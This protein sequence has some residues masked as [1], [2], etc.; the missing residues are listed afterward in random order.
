MA[1]QFSLSIIIFF[2]I[3]LGLLFMFNDIIMISFFNGAYNRQ[4]TGLN[5][6]VTRGM[7]ILIFILVIIGLG[8]KFFDSM[9][10][11]SSAPSYF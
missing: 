11:G 2:C 1:S 7:L 5:T 4:V 3:G 10:S 8:I 9:V 6:N